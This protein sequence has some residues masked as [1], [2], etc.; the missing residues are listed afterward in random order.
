MSDLLIAALMDDNGPWPEERQSGLFLSE[1]SC[2]PG[3]CSQKPRAAD[4]LCVTGLHGQAKDLGSQL[5]MQDQCALYRMTGWLQGSLVL[6]CHHR[7]AIGMCHRASRKTAMGVLKNFQ[8][9]K[10]VHKFVIKLQ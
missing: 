10:Q 5:S 7:Y 2:T 1:R 9:V 8:E 4:D 6:H 3:T